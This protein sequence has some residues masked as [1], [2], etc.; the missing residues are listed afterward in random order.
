MPATVTSGL[1]PVRQVLSNGAVVIAQETAFSPAVTINLAFRAGSLYEPDDLGG[2]A[3]FAG[4]VIDRGTASRVADAIAEALD[5][6][7]VALKVVTNRH[8]TVLSCTALSED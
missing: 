8:L 2:V 6:R 3:W 4:R 1:A 5:D 7:G